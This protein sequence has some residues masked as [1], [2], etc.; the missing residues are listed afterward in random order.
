MPGSCGDLAVTSDGIQ[1]LAYVGSQRWIE[2]DPDEMKVITVRAPAMAFRWFNVPVDIVRW[3]QLEDV[4][5][6]LTGPARRER[7]RRGIERDANLGAGTLQVY[8][9]STPNLSYKR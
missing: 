7:Y 6:T 9:N 5:Y 2:A 3:R 8:L 4:V 1:V